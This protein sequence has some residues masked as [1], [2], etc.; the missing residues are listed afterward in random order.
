MSTTPRIIITSGEPAGIGPDLCL[1]VAQHEWPAQLIF[2]ADEHLLQSR[3]RDLGVPVRISYYDP[4]HCARAHRSGE[5]QV[6]HVPVREPVAAGKL[7]TANARY[8]LDL[9][10]RA[11]DGCM[12]GEF[13]AM[14]TAPVQKS[15][16]IDAGVPFSGH[17]EYLAHR[18]GGALP[19]MM[20]AAENLRVALVT[21]H[22]PLARVPAAI[23]PQLL[24]TVLRTLH[25]DLR[26]KFGIDH[27]RILVL[28]L[29]P[30]A[31]ENG[32]LCRE[33]IEVILPVLQTLRAEGMHLTGPAPADTAF[34]PRLL[35]H[36][37][38][39]LAMY[40][41]QGL[42]VLKYAGFGHAVN[43]TLGLPLIRTSVDHGTAL[44]LAGKGTADAGSLT[45]AT[46]LAI[47]LAQ[48]S[49]V[50]SAS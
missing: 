30:H 3:A 24:T 31:G 16:I 39:V 33:E 37:D 41:D 46:V 17:T 48:T 12:S 35:E 49:R 45:A 13:A 27:P 28:G 43:V 34:T 6:M 7:N 38:A 36:A 1:A 23:Q 47:E 20:L 8:V 29:N 11:C 32:H 2:A 25:H 44:E 10:D 14:V 18:S 50:S 4:G 9:L 22:L 19:V 42:P 21:T 40:H 15:V 5:L 26:R